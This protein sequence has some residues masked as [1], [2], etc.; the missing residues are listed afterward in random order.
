LA[1]PAA[2]AKALRRLARFVTWSNGQI[3]AGEQRYKN[4]SQLIAK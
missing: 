1:P 4:K 3:S 2:W